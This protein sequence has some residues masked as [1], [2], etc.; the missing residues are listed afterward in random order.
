MIHN[1]KIGVIS[2]TPG[3]GKSLISYCYAASISRQRDWKVIW[4]HL[5][6]VM[7]RNVPN[8]DLIIFSEGIKFTKTVPEEFMLKFLREMMPKPDQKIILVLDGY[9]DASAQIG[10]AVVHWFR[11]DKENRRVL[12]VSSMGSDVRSKPHKDRANNIERFKQVSW[13]WGEYVEAISSEEFYNSIADMLDAPCIVDSPLGKLRAKFFYAGSCARFMF[14]FKTRQVVAE[15]GK[16]L[17]ETDAKALFSSAG[18]PQA[19]NRL[20]G[21]SS[22]YE[23]RPVSDYVHVCLSERSAPEEVYKL[24]S[25]TSSSANPALRGILDRFAPR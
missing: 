4:V 2:G 8:M 14:S 25:G 21:C 23:L 10:K 16:S 1:A 9:T 6:S 18:T 13:T 7:S 12:T 11:A 20:F 3:T 24:L 22:S 15:I 17:A 19:I 5:S